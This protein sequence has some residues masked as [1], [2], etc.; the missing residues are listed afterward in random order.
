MWLVAYKT[1]KDNNVCAGS[2]EYHKVNAEHGDTVI[3]PC[4]ATPSSDVQW[5]QN[6]TDGYFNHVY[7]NGTIWG[8]HNI[9]LLFSVINASAGNYSLRIYTV[10]PVYSGLYDCFDGNGSRIIGY[11]LDA[12]GMFI[13]I[14]E[15]VV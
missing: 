7:M 2:L 14:L 13:N 12:K 5:I 3:L 6:R 15:H 8:Y 9:R 10:H 11:Y 1:D 4:N